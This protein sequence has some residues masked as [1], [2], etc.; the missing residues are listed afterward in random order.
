LV[1]CSSHHLNYLDANSLYA[2]AQSEPL[3]VDLRKVTTCTGR[4]HSMAAPLQ[5]A[6]LVIIIIIIIMQMDGSE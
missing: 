3:P 1:D 6:Q 5:A 4:G 2:T